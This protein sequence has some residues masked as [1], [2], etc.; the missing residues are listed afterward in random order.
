MLDDDPANEFIE[1]G[2]EL[3]AIQVLLRLGGMG[4]SPQ[5]VVNADKKPL[6]PT[7]KRTS[8]GEDQ[9][10]RKTGIT[11]LKNCRLRLRDSSRNV[12]TADE[13]QSLQC[14]LDSAG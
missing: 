2:P 11:I 12:S 1:V 3:S 5:D 9:A 13:G 14:D 8:E 10:I 7:Q 4:I 6:A